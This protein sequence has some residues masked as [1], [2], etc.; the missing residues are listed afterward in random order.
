MPKKEK[1]TKIQSVEFDSVMHKQ[2]TVL[3]NIQHRSFSGTVRYLCE[4]SLKSINLGDGNAT[5][6]N[7]VTKRKAS[8]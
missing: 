2:I 6:K 3:A 4:E 7:N 8:L 1:D 5:P